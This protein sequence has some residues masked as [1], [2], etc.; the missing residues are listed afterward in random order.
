M[1]EIRLSDRLIGRR[2]GAL[3]VESLTCVQNKMGCYMLLCRCDC[4]DTALVPKSSLDA[5][6]RKSCGC[7]VTKFRDLTGM[8]IGRLKVVGVIP[9]LDKHR[10][11]RWRCLCECGKSVNVITSHLTGCSKTR[12][13]GCLSREAARERAI[14]RNKSGSAT[15]KR[16]GLT[17]PAKEHWERLI[18]DYVK[19]NPMCSRADIVENVGGG[20]RKVERYIREL[21]R[22]KSLSVKSFGQGST[23]RLR[24]FVGTNPR[25]VKPKSLLARLDPDTYTAAKSDGLTDKQI[26]ATLH[27]CYSG[28]KSW[29]RRNGVRVG[30]ATKSIWYSQRASNNPNIG[31]PKKYPPTP[32]VPTEVM[33]EILTAASPAIERQIEILE[34]SGMFAPSDLTEQLERMAWILECKKVSSEEIANAYIQKGVRNR[35]YTKAKQMRKVRMLTNY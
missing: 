5:G 23:V 31:R 34:N 32:E 3:T 15:R 14:E 13:C 20:S 1:V 7:L 29:K 11:R 2:Y 21:A 16:W 19:H 12:S 17:K 30:S 27:V 24:Y 22:S 25:A 4:G 35:F 6:K 9:G 26:A 28:L 10:K 8:Q 18:L 33:R